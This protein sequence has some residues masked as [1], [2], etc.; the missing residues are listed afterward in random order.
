VPIS[1][2]CDKQGLQPTVLY[3]WQKESVLLRR[4]E[5]SLKFRFRVLELRYDQGVPG[6][7]R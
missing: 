4:R 1:E 2:L 7:R 5:Q 6:A 3:R